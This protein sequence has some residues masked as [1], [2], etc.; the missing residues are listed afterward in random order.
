M[1]FKQKMWYI[2][3]MSS[4]LALFT[5]LSAFA[6][7]SDTNVVPDV[8]NIYMPAISN[9]SVQEST[10]NLTPET[11]MVEGIGLVNLLKGQDRG[12][13]VYTI[14]ENDLSAE[15]LAVLDTYFAQQVMDEVQAAATN[16]L[17]RVSKSNQNTGSLGNTRSYTSLSGWAELGLSGWVEINASGY[18]SGSWIGTGKASQITLYDS[19]CFNGVAASIYLAWPPQIQ[20]SSSSNCGNYQSSPFYTTTFASQQYNNADAT[21]RLGGW[22]L[23]GVTQADRP[24]IRIGTTDY[25]PASTVTLEWLW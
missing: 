5:T 8:Y 12:A 3:L 7:S 1:F 21:T 15:Q 16:G 19:V 10:T 20:L 24:T 23:H 6:Q 14:G 4:T 22:A 13:T 17:K 25:R 18:S 9:H 2:M 11:V